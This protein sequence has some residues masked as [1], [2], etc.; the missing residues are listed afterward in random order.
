MAAIESYPNAR[1]EMGTFGRQGT[2]R[3]AGTSARRVLAVAIVAVGFVA[4]GAVDARADNTTQPDDAASQT[5]AA[6]DNTASKNGPASTNGHA[7][8]NGPASAND[9]GPTSDAGS[10]VSVSPGDAA[11]PAGK[12]VASF[13]VRGDSKV[14][15][16]M[17]G[18]LL[19]LEI[20]DRVTPQ[21]IPQLESTLLSSELFENAK[22]VFE[23]TPNG[24]VQIAATVHDRLSWFVAPAIYVLPSSY[25]F[26]VGYAENNLLGEDKKVL[27]YG[28]LGNRTSLFFATF[29]DPAVDGTRMQLRFDVYA[30]HKQLLEYANPAND[31]RSQL[32]DRETTTTFLDAGALVGYKFAWWLIGDMRLR[33]AYTYFRNSQDANGN[34]LPTPERDGWDVSGQARLTLDSRQHRFGVTWGPYAQLLLDTSVPGLDDYNYSYATLRAYYSW[35]LFGDHELELRGA[36]GIG[37][38]L[39]FHEELT[40]GGAIDLRGYELEQFRGD[41]RLMA[42]SEYSIPVA[43]W[44]TF[45]FRALGFVDLGYAGL[46]SPD[47]SGKRNYLPSQYDGA[48][49]LRSDVGV[50]IR[51]YVS[52]IVL[53]LL[54]FDL[55]YGLEAH[56]PEIYFELGLTD[57]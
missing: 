10:T 18:R 47:P 12:R 7:S 2:R 43:T 51:V 57:F 3:V 1:C 25:S 54:G 27:V 28:Q 9:A 20:G 42:R 49:W 8:T 21:Q 37:R 19:H 55:G 24:E 48:H 30:Y 53:P 26:G 35:C 22:I 17:L 38:H 50:G 29:L 40:L 16:R 31:A 33:G 15:D 44:R 39:P 41:R 5:A 32:V 13:K 6:S 23:D 45:A 46:S 11:L 52:T 34:P 14:H 56:S 36:A 4:H